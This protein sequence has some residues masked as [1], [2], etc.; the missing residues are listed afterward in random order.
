MQADVG[1]A[2]RLLGTDDVVLLSTSTCGYCRKLRA[3]LSEWGVAY[4]ERDIE[5]EDEA[6]DAFN[7]VRARGV[8]VLLVDDQVMR[9]YS[10]ER[11]HSMLV[12]AGVIDS[13]KTL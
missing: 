13:S 7:A 4:V 9:G 3:D 10:R 1:K 11:A 5:V 6:F 2:R 12:E 8:P